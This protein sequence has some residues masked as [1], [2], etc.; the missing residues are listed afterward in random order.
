MPAVKHMKWW[1]WGVE[2]IAFDHSDKP[3][4]APFVLDKVGIDLSAPGTPPPSFEDIDVPASR[5]PGSRTS[6]ARRCGRRSARSTS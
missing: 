5:R 1:G 2:G 3:R 4:M 6:S